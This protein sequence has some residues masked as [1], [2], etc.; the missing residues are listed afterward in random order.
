MEYFQTANILRRRLWR[1][2]VILQVRTDGSPRWTH[3]TVTTTISICPDASVYIY[4]LQ[5]RFR[6]SGWNISSPTRDGGYGVL[7]YGWWRY[8][9]DHR[10]L[11]W[12]DR[13]I[14]PLSLK[15]AT[16][17][18]PVKTKSAYS[19]GSRG[20]GQREGHSLSNHLPPLFT[21]ETPF[22]KTEDPRNILL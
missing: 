3:F 9:V 6:K 19:G 17:T 5:C 8:G 1:S 13:F 7:G 2:L 14:L 12:L 10:P 21:Y 4:I 20:I 16:L 22:S 18:L 15:P 11:W